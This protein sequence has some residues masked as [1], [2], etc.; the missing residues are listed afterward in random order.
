M[1]YVGTALIKIIGFELD[2]IWMALWEN[3]KRK[4]RIFFRALSQGGHSQLC[5]GLAVVGF[6]DISIISDAVCTVTRTH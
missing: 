2:A 3:L 5:S 4:P 6:Q 1:E